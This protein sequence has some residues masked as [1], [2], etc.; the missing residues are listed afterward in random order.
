MTPCSR[1]VPPTG[2]TWAGRSFS[3]CSCSG[4]ATPSS[5][6]S[7]IP[8]PRRFEVY[9]IAV[10]N[11]TRIYQ[12]YSARHRFQ[13]F[14]S[15]LL[16]GDFLRALRPDELVTAL[17]GVNLKIEKGQTFGIIGENGSGKSTLLKVVAGIAKPSS[18]RVRTQG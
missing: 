9:A 10:D 4:P 13:T 3:P 18:G 16:K 14:K 6:G 7:A 2:S 8:S 11:V 12:K 5:T 15:A 1:G 17:D